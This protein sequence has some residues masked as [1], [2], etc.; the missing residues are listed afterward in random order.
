MSGISNLS[1]YIF[2]EGGV[3]IRRHMIM[4][5]VAAALGIQPEVLKALLPP[6]I[7]LLTRGEISSEEFWFRFSA[8]TGIHPAEDYLRTFFHP[9]KDDPTFRLVERLAARARVVCGTN[10]IDSHHKI[11]LELG[12][13]APFHA[14]YASHLLHVMK[15]DIEFWLRILRAEGVHPEQAFFADDSPDN[16]RVARELGINAWLYTD[17]HSLELQLKALG[18]PL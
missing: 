4:P 6:D 15:P 8:R 9:V 14:V 2:D 1:L 11:N 5:D 3:L 18:A 7:A 16:V 12:M 10:T 17:A 13:Y